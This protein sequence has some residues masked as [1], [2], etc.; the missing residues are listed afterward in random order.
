ML[1]VC[2]QQ[3]WP[4]DKPIGQMVF[5]QIIPSHLGNL[6]AQ[7]V[8][9]PKQEIVHHLYSKP[10]KQFF[11][12][13]SPYPMLLWIT[14]LHTQ[15]HGTQWFTCYLD[16]KDPNS[17]EIAECLA[18]TGFYRLL[19]FCLEEPQRC[20]QVMTASLSR[21]QCQ[22]LQQWIDTSQSLQPTAR[23]IEG[24]RILQAE[25]ENL[26]SQLLGTLDFQNLFVPAPVS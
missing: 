26:K 19:L 24:R 20:A 14:A 17:L 3:S 5:P 18:K 10:Y 7:W 8:M 22:R 25:F 16:L 23:P 6:A 13:E 2:L 9:L 12:T 1:Q 21:E 11:F 4:D 15:P